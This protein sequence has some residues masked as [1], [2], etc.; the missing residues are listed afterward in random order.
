[1]DELI[2]VITTL[3]SV[4]GALVSVIFSRRSARGERLEAADEIAMKFRE[5]MLH[6][7]FNLETRLYNILELGFFRRFL[8]ADNSEQEREYAVC[9]TL[10]LFAQYFC[11]VEILRRAS[12]FID[13]RND[14]RD[15]QYVKALENVRNTF[16]DSITIQESTFRIFRGEQRALG[17]VMLFP[18]ADPPPGV[19]RWDCLGY[20]AFVQA[21]EEPAMA[22]WFRSLRSDIDQVS[23]DLSGHDYRLRLLQRSLM[24]LIDAIDPD[25]WRV[26]SSLR[27][28][29]RE[30]GSQPGIAGVEAHPSG[31]GPA[32]D[33][34]ST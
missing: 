24:D 34:G 29:C 16:T 15:R 33:G 12:Q 5:P 19:P 14:Q 3:I 1:V 30:P 26:P 7:A 9:N 22:R 4:A 10:Y 28:R 11:W 17:E 32:R 31:S 13:P 23:H 2:P 27:R 25:A 18:V 20:A 8:T 6:A 21:L